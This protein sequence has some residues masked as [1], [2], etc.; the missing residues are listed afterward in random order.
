MNKSILVLVILAITIPSILSAT[1]C[2][3]ANT[4]ITDEVFY[5]L[6]T[7]VNPGELKNVGCC[8]NG[9]FTANGGTYT[10]SDKKTTGVCSPVVAASPCTQYN[11]Y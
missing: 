4:P 8:V 7:E 3:N 10:L 5:Q 2:F 11:L 9:V 6:D 1:V